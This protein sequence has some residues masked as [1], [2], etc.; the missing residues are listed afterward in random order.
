MPL[1]LG[2][3]EFLHG[4]AGKSGALDFL[5]VLF[6]RWLPYGLVLAAAYFLLKRKDAAERMWGICFAGLTII[7][8]R[9]IFVELIS[10][11]FYRARPNVAL[12][13]DSL[14]PA[15]T[16]AF[17]SGHASAF[18]ALAAVLYFLDKRWGGWF[19]GFVLL[20]GI[21][22]VIA[23]VHWPT[24]ILGGLAVGLISFFIIK[25]II[26]SYRPQTRQMPVALPGEEK[27]PVL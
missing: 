15:S 2:L 6:A 10:Q 7:V 5:F 17:P 18:F 11:A 14:I 25:I 9:G 16:S 23:G 8:S 1:E 20:N 26:G 4:L 27:A 19:F 22:R 12:G 24:D 21:M 3:F 13:F